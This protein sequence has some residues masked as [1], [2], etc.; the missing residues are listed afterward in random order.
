MTLE[1]IKEESEISR[2]PSVNTDSFNRSSEKKNT[3][4]IKDGQHDRL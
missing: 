4:S 2:K 3:A 1:A